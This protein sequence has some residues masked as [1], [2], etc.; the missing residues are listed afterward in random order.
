MMGHFVP[1][2]L[3]YIP[4]AQHVVEEPAAPSVIDEPPMSKEEDFGLQTCS[5]DSSLLN[6]ISS[7]ETVSDSDDAELCSQDSYFDACGD[8][9]F[10]SLDAEFNRNESRNQ[11]SCSGLY[12][13]C[14][15]V[16][17]PS[18]KESC[19]ASAEKR[20]GGERVLSA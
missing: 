9:P 15:S 14:C 13:C 4:A 10:A 16:Y 1:A 12:R 6:S 8:D 17:D 2:P 7:M 18:F 19:D 20:V 11:K 5:S 3:T